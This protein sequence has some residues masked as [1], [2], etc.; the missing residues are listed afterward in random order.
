MGGHPVRNLTG[1]A[2]VEQAGTASGERLRPLL[3]CEGVGGTMGAHERA[4][5]HMERKRVGIL[6]FDDVE[7]LDFCG[8]LE[9]F[10][11]A[12][13]DETRRLEEPSPFEPLLV[14]GTLAPIATTGGMR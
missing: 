2:Q 10:S 6:V 14:A 8:P 11:I 3:S 5:V 13:L 9:V 7:V 12:R 1:A 4:R